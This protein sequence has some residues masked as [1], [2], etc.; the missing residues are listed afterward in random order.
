MSSRGVRLPPREAARIEGLKTQLKRLLDLST[1]T[2]RGNVPKTAA[3][4]EHD[5]EEALRI[6][7]DNAAQNLT[8]PDKSSNTLFKLA[9]ETRNERVALALVE[10]VADMDF[11]F[12]A[13]LTR[14]MLS[15]R[16][17]MPDV[18]RSLIAGGA[19]LDV[20]DAAGQTALMWCGIGRRNLAAGGDIGPWEECAL[21][22]VA[23]GAD[24][25][26]VSR[27]GATALSIAQ[28]APR[29]DYIIGVLEGASTAEEILELLRAADAAPQP[30][31]AA[32]QPPVAQPPADANV[33][34][35]SEGV[36]KPE[37]DAA[38]AAVEHAPVLR[39]APQTSVRTVESSNYR[40]VGPYP[41]P[42]RR[43]RELG[44][45]SETGDILPGQ[46]RTDSEES[47]AAA[48]VARRRATPSSDPTRNSNQA[49]F[50]EANV[51][52]RVVDLQPQV[53]RPRSALRG[54][55]A[56]AAAESLPQPAAEEQPFSSSS[57]S[58]TA[59]PVKAALVDTPFESDLKREIN[60][61][62][63]AGALRVLAQP[64]AVFIP[65]GESR[66]FNLACE[67]HLEVVAMK[68]MARGPA[69]L[70]TNSKGFTPLMKACN[71]GLP[72]LVRALLE[73]GGQDINASVKVGN[74]AFSAIMFA[75][76][77]DGANVGTPAEITARRDEICLRLI[78]AGASDI[79]PALLT[80][81]GLHDDLRVAA[82]DRVAALPPNPENDRLVADTVRAFRA[83]LTPRDHTV[84][85]F[86]LL[87][88]EIPPTLA[89][90]QALLEVG[91]NADYTDDN[92]DTLLIEAMTH[93]CPLA[94]VQALLA[95]GASV[96]LANSSQITP[97]M[98][99]VH[100][101]IY[102][103][104]LAP[105]ISR[106]TLDAKDQLGNTALAQA[107]LA[108]NTA[109]VVALVGRG[110]TVGL[111]TGRGRT[112]LMVCCSKGNMAAAGTLLVA[113]ANLDARDPSGNSALRYA[114]E[115]K[116]PDVAHLLLL[117]GANV[118]ELSGDLGSNLA[119]TRQILNTAVPNAGAAS[120]ARRSVLTALEYCVAHPDEPRFRN[121][122]LVAR[123][124]ALATFEPPAGGGA[125]IS[126]SK[127]GNDSDDALRAALVAATAP[128]IPMTFSAHVISSACDHAALSEHDVAL[129]AGPDP[130]L[131]G[132]EEF[133][134]GAHGHDHAPREL[135]EDS[136]WDIPTLASFRQDITERMRSSTV[137]V[138]ELLKC[139]F[140]YGKAADHRPCAALVRPGIVRQMLAGDQPALFDAALAR[141]RGA[142]IRQELSARRA[143]T[144][145][146]DEFL[147]S[148]CFALRDEMPVMMRDAAV[149]TIAVGYEHTFVL[150]LSPFNGTP[151]AMLGVAPEDV[152][153][154]IAAAEAQLA[155]A[156]PDE[157]GGIER[158]LESL[159]QR[160]R[161]QSYMCRHIEKQAVDT[162]AEQ[163]LAQVTHGWFSCL[164]CGRICRNGLGDHMVEW[165]PDAGFEDRSTSNRGLWDDP[166]VPEV[167]GQRSEGIARAFVLFQAIKTA[168]ATGLY[169][170]LDASE[171]PVSALV[172]AAVLEMNKAVR[173]NP[174]Y[175]ELYRQIDAALLQRPVHARTADE[176]DEFAGDPANLNFPRRHG[177]LTVEQVYRP[178]PHVFPMWPEAVVFAP[179]REAVV[180][181][182]TAVIARFDAA[183]TAVL[184]AAAP[185]PR[186]LTP[187]E[188]GQR[189]I[190]LLYRRVPPPRQ[191][192]FEEFL[193]EP[194]D[195][196]VKD[197]FSGYTSLMIILR[198]A[199]N[200]REN[201]ERLLG[202][203]A[204]VNIVDDN[205]NNVLWHAANQHTPL[206][207]A[208]VERLV[209]AGANINQIS[210]DGVT[211][212]VAAL[213]ND[214]EIA[215]LFIRLGA[216]IEQAR[217]WAFDYHRVDMFGTL[218]RAYAVVP[219]LTPQARA[220]WLGLTLDD[221][222]TTLADIQ[223]IFDT[224]PVDFTVLDYYGDGLLF[225]ALR[226]TQSPLE[227][228]DKLLREG[229]N[230]NL[231][232]RH[233]ESLLQNILQYLVTTSEMVDRVIAAGADI[234]FVNSEGET[235]LAIA[236]L[237]D[238]DEPT[239][240][241]HLA[242][243]L[244]LRGADVPYVRTWAQDRPR[245]LREL[246]APDIRQA[247]AAA[248][249]A[250]ARPPPNPFIAPAGG[251]PLH[252]L[253]AG[254]GAPRA[255]P[256]NPFGA[257]PAA[258]VAGGR[259]PFGA[260]PAPPAVAGAG[261]GN[262]FGA[263]PAAA[264]V[265]PAPVP[266]AP[267]NP[268][269]A[270]PATG[271]APVAAGRNPFGAPPPAAAAAAV[272]P[273]AAAPA[274]AVNPFA[275]A[276]AAPAV[277]PFA[278]AAAPVVNP[279]AP[280]AAAVNPFEAAAASRLAAI[281]PINA[282]DQ[283]RAQEAID[284]LQQAV[285]DAE[286]S[287]QEAHRA[288]ADAQREVEAE[289]RRGDAA[290]LAAA[291]L[292]RVEAERDEALA[293]AAALEVRAILAEAIAVRGRI[294]RGGGATVAPPGIGGRL[295]A[296]MFG[297]PRAAAP[298]AVAAVPM[299]VQQAVAA[300]RAPAGGIAAPAAV[301]RPAPP[302]A[303]YAGPDDDF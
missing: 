94:I 275:A 303:P 97:L 227:I 48:E 269:G 17:G 43:G 274:P 7:G 259:N 25:T 15:C 101:P 211:P 151:F 132:F 291:G 247:I 171:G 229:A 68:L 138:A 200:T 264:A 137:T 73:Q 216:D 198:S 176:P 232:N 103:E 67:K 47:A 19:A 36:L 271:A 167:C 195:I 177:D 207:D 39:F 224:G 223:R 149:G 256:G 231:V 142:S 119:D 282:F 290:A 302:P 60:N 218:S 279:F 104:L 33:I 78:A 262:P 237:E 8:L 35:D 84:R 286:T 242:P 288:V 147:L 243:L 100:T 69:A 9:C 57:S 62:Q 228:F 225:A 236:L 133:A 249:A 11:R 95:A 168:R 24:R 283:V 135:Y 27:S 85:L 295:W 41:Q 89:T 74:I 239:S 193:R 281:G 3:E 116:N 70:V 185:V 154:E 197:S 66:A 297:R 178:G 118:S 267:G 263:A 87:T 120:L 86:S 81:L 49:Y 21:V 113:G 294:G 46:F 301:G 196:N 272:N 53:G 145:I 59:A 106:E 38:F 44:Q 50:S 102:T 83:Y 134:D 161:G 109:A 31:V 136:L 201:I 233:G 65:G 205:G 157:V 192:E 52:P 90:V 141:A 20:V 184:G 300:F 126:E 127:E 159:R 296:M 108:G 175:T 115:A 213:Q 172:A 257:A 51:A 148:H 187:Q 299:T 96:S 170:E 2:A 240:S 214:T 278:A 146:T 99:A 105:L 210:P 221:R 166:P 13:G 204:D 251:I 64:D 122:A 160:R 156:P 203:G 22:L 155:A 139:P 121:P 212:L 164:R 268:F 238:A 10:H 129:L 140:N 244:I 208:V 235:A 255:A 28:E 1:L 183:L 40:V 131:F 144:Q 265:A 91:A 93:E 284:Q 248:A 277:N 23:A 217:E 79:P 110:A 16:F 82:A 6:I 77:Q 26:I 215:P 253:A 98:A 150:G 202:A 114:M 153:V 261:G 123:F 276:P 125:G 219:N 234:N 273:F 186:A 250:A 92:G 5:T 209:E 4:L 252:V 190:D 188:R 199:L 165:D 61:R 30:A 181:D 111:A 117:L 42:R 54:A 287:E 76:A 14:L 292:V 298:V 107:C 88:D 182:D 230:V 241:R 191:D 246:E 194:I 80:R 280:A 58:I 179:P 173:K 254:G 289:R 71:Y 162:P 260:A 55:R 293:R 169:L 37:G 220:Y 285:R 75:S 158:R 18:T 34:V 258:P 266:A 124:P 72:L 226:G 130:E 143:K 112:P 245:V 29:M 189:L 32:P 222:R 45:Y 128:G 180:T 174:R 63:S 152:G 206:P 270:A 163:Q 56:S 12:T